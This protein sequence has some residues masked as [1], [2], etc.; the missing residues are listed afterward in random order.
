LEE[1][2]FEKFDDV[3]SITR[4]KLQLAASSSGAINQDLLHNQIS[5]IP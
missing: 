5:L 3:Q 2:R 1:K 4:T